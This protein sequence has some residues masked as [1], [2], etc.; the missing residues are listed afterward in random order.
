MHDKYAFSA[1]SYYLK[2]HESTVLPELRNLSTIHKS[3]ETSN[4]ITVLKNGAGEMAQ[5][6]RVFALW[7]Y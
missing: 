6:A 3:E 1:L 7:A 4:N 2:G 5:Q